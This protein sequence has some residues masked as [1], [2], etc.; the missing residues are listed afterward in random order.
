[1]LTMLHLNGEWPFKRTKHIPKVLILV[2]DRLQF[3]LFAVSV[4]K[5][6]SDTGIDNE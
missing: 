5:E 2:C 6:V 4:L 1:M 3:L